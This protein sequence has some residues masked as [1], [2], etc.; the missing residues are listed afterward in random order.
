MSEGFYTQGF[1]TLTHVEID[2]FACETLK[3]SMRYYGYEDADKLML[4]EDI[5]SKDILAKIKKQSENKHRNTRKERLFSSN[6]VD[7]EK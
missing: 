5:T 4:E 6:R 2:H 7:S 3:K 1:K